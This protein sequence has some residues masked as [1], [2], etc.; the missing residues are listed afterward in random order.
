MTTFSRGDIV[1]HVTNPKVKMVVLGLDEGDI[2]VSY[3]TKK[4]VQYATLSP[5]FLKKK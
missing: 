2:N 4:G 1:T 5:E 3:M